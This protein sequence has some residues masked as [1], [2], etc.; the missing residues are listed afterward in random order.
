MTSRMSTVGSLLATTGIGKADFGSVSAEGEIRGLADHVANPPPTNLSFLQPT[1]TRYKMSVSL[2]PPNTLGFRRPLTQLVKRSLT[3]TNHNAQPIAFKVKTTAP[4]LYCV[5]PNSGRVEPGE[6]LEVAV[7]LQ[8]M[9]EEPPLNTKCKDKFL[10]QS[11]IITQDKETMALQDIWANTDANEEG[12]VY[13]QKLRVAYLPPEGQTLEEEDETAHANQSSFINP[14]DVTF[15]TVRQQP[16]AN[17]HQPI[18]PFAAPPPPQEPPR[19]ST[20]PA[21]D[22]SVAREESQDHTQPQFNNIPVVNEPSHRA[23]TPP[24]AVPQVAAVPPPQPPVQVEHAPQPVRA[25]APVPVPPPAPARA[26]SPVIITQENPINE[27]LV[28]ENE[29][30][31]GQIES[32][33]HELALQR[34]ENQEAQQAVSELRRRRRSSIGDSGS[35][36]RTAVDEPNIHQDGVPLNVVVLISFTVFFM[37]YIFF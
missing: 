26:P 16:P 33:K 8:A 4:K 22:Y 20:P 29:E 1:P 25:A 11:T 21:V 13:Q 36:V 3:I 30:L 7:M 10:I 32:L 9:K 19:P 15:D 27:Q 5:R 18:P 14:S 37:T 35:D 34:A 24:P 23:P 31:R 17:G 6:S 2:N 12:K 28:V